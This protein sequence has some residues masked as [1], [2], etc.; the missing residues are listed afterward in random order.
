MPFKKYSTRETI[1]GDGSMVKNYLYKEKRVYCKSG[2]GKKGHKKKPLFK[3][4]LISVITICYRNLH[5][6][7]LSGCRIH[8]HCGCHNHHH[9]EVNPF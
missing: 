8:R 1:D 5:H 9:H 3:A 4:F 7:R 6:H 2:V